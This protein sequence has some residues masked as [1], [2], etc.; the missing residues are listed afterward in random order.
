MDFGMFA[1]IDDIEYLLGI[2]VS[3]EWL[4]VALG[5]YIVHTHTHTRCA[6]DDSVFTRDHMDYLSQ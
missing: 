4:C 6:D 5:S 2:I 3:F 1:T